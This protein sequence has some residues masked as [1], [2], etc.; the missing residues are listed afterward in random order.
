MSEQDRDTA[1]PCPSGDQLAGINARIGMGTGQR[2]CL[3]FKRKRTAVGD[4]QRCFR[5]TRPKR[6]SVPIVVKCEAV[7]SDPDPVTAKSHVIGI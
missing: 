7:V 1:P 3:G 5:A 2:L 6:G 4:R